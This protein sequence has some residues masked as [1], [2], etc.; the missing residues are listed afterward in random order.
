MKENVIRTQTSGKKNAKFIFSFIVLLGLIAGCKKKDSAPVPEKPVLTTAAITG[1]TTNAAVSGGN[2]SSGSNITERGV[3]WGTTSA[4]TVS[5]NGG[6]TSDG[7][8]TGSFTSNLTSLSASTVYYLR[9][10]AT[11]SLGT[12]YGNEVSFFTEDEPPVLPAAAS[13]AG[14]TR[15]KF[16]D[17]FRSYNTIDTATTGN[18]GFNWY[19]DRPFGGSPVLR[20][21]YNIKDG[22]L[23]LTNT[24]RSQGWA[25]STYSVK[26]GKGHGFRYGYFE[27]RIKFDPSKGATSSWFPT[28]WSFSINHAKTNDP[29]HWA[30]LDF[31]EAYTGGFSNWDGSFF[32]TVHD[33]A[34][35]SRTHYQN[36]NNYQP[37]TKSADY[38]KFH[39]YGCLWKPG[40]ITWYFDGRALMTQKYSATATPDPLANGTT[41]PTPA[42]V[43]SILDTDPL[44]M[45]LI[46]G[47]CEE[48][49]MYV[50]W[51]RVW[52]Q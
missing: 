23:T 33:W 22:I 42:G 29:S 21:A 6:K 8:G 43:F 27:A 25:L 26:T 41:T 13:A 49:P 44:G 1:I 12:E 17:E 37:S 30:E 36:A 18:E 3:V 5:A 45:L 11:N 35:D 2:I 28:W 51:V 4:P 38:T 46:L 34:D 15:L 10:Y 39:T 48:W 50:D 16:D 52:Q 9:A 24:G 40:E 32:G 14:F 31:F 47:S 7:T 19:T 20:S